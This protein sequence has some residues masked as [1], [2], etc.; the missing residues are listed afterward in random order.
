MEVPEPSERTFD[1]LIDKIV[2]GLHF[3]DAARHL[4]RDAEVPS[5]PGDFLA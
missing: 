5:S 1:L 3:D 4:Q 2:R